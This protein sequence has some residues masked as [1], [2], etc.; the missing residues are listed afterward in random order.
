[1]QDFSNRTIRSPRNFSRML[2]RLTA[3]DSA[4]LTLIPSFILEYQAKRGPKSWRSAK[5]SEHKLSLLWKIRFNST[6]LF[7]IWDRY[8]FWHMC[9]TVERWFSKGN[10]RTCRNTWQ[11]LHRSDAIERCFRSGVFRKCGKGTWSRGGKI[12]SFRTKLWKQI[13]EFWVLFPC[14]KYSVAY[15]VVAEG[16]VRTLSLLI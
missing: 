1:M 5:Q 14:A 12:Y 9:K 4:V 15:G 10:F 6:S 2:R 11:I 7:M 13:V 3:V 16:L 8:A